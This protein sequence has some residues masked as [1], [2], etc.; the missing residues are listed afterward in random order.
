[1]PSYYDDDWD[2]YDVGEFTGDDTDE[3]FPE[4]DESYFSEI[5]EEHQEDV[6]GIP[7]IPSKWKRVCM[8]GQHFQVSNKGHIMKPD[9]Y[10]E[11]HKGVEESGS[12]YRTFTFVTTDG[13]PR[14]YYMHDIVWRAFH[15]EPPTG[16]EV[17]HKVA[18]TMKRKRHYSNALHN[19]T[20]MPSRVEVRPTIFT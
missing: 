1:M 15:G 17:Q 14:T 3:D 2:K 7:V 12:P 6:F 19:L 18:E 10:F 11:V 9:T 4:D 5:Q 16:W 8:G 20:I 13:T